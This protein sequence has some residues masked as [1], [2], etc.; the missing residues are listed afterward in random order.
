[1]GI[2]NNDEWNFKDLQGMR[3]NTKSLKRNERAHK[4]ILIAPSKHLRLSRSPASIKQFLSTIILAA[5]RFR[6]HISR[7]GWQPI[8]QRSFRTNNGFPLRF[9]KVVA[10]P[11]LRARTAAPPAD[12]NACIISS[13]PEPKHVVPFRSKAL[14]PSPF[15]ISLPE[16]SRAPEQ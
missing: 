12:Q 11:P 14:Q 7:L 5:G 10:R 13:L 16:G 3:R 9:R 4:E 6:V 15:G 8:P 1:M 2:E